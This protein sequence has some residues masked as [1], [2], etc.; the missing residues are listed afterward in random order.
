MKKIPIFLTLILIFVFSIYSEPTDAQIMLAANALEVPF[1][2]LKQFVQS[3]RG[4]NN[5]SIRN[6]SHKSIDDLLEYFSNYFSV[7]DK[8]WMWFQIIGAIDGCRVNINDS[9][10]EIYKFDINDPG[11]KIIIE[12]ALNTNTMSVM[13]M[14]FPALANGSFLI[15]NYTSHPDRNNLMEIFKNF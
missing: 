15:V 6:N 12:N 14:T 8:E 11:Q 1:E 13:G 9:S 2:D 5:I 3:Y 10:I 7:S 4:N